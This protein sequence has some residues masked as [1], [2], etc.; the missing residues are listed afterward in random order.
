MS[1][2]TNGQWEGDSTPPSRWFPS[3]PDTSERRFLET[4]NKKAKAQHMT[5]DTAPSSTEVPYLWIPLTDGRGELLVQPDD[6]AEPE[7]GSIILTQGIHGTAWQRFFAGPRLW[8]RA[9]GGSPTE[10]SVLIGQRNVVLVYDAP[11]REDQR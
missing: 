2:S 11:V 8:H 1:R 6:A 5:T 7:P 4:V 9:G 3:N 10:W